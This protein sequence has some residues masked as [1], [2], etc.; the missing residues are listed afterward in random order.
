VDDFLY[1]CDDAYRRRE[2]LAYEIKMLKSIN[3][4]LG[5]PLSYRYLRRFARVCI[6][7][8]V[9]SFYTAMNNDALGCVDSVE[10]VLGS[11]SSTN[12]KY[13]S[14]IPLSN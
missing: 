2:L 11:L 7:Y 9:C 1:I 8:L 4:D 13:F 10:V 14:D 6:H 3:F 12:G 5:I